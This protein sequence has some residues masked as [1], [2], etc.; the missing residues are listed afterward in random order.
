MLPLSTRFPSPVR[1]ELLLVAIPD[2]TIPS[3]PTS[4]LGP[5]VALHLQTEPRQ[6]LLP[7]QAYL[8]DLMAF[9]LQIFLTTTSAPV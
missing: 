6:V 3:W 8:S 7:L 9:P 5:P 4:L 2:I 1:H